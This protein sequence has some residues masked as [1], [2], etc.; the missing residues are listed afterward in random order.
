MEQNHAKGF[1]KGGRIMANYTQVLASELPIL[2]DKGNYHYLN[3][4]A[5]K[6]EYI[7]VGWQQS[8][9]EYIALYGT[10]K[11]NLSITDDLVDIIQDEQV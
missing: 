11:I 6:G 3:E 7:K 2:D 4:V 9:T 10:E 5:G 1:K 8:G